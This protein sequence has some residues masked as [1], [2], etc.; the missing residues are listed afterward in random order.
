MAIVTKQTKS[1]GYIV[2]KDIYT[3]L[4][5]TAIK[6]ELETELEARYL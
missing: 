4:K 5:Y 2:G 1:L 6:I 3:N